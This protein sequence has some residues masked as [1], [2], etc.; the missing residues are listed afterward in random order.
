MKEDLRYVIMP[1]MLHIIA[2][3][4]SK[5]YMNNK[6]IFFDSSLQLE[7][8]GPFLVKRIEVNCILK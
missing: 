2:P 5:T 7:M 8:T 4:T 1:D 3:Q 6:T